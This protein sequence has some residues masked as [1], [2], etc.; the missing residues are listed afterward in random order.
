MD[1]IPGDTDLPHA[2]VALEDALFACQLA[3]HAGVSLD[4]ARELHR[5]TV[6]KEETK[7]LLAE[8][9]ATQ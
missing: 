5:E 6:T 4:R 9:R 7:R 3:L 8:R 1:G 2:I